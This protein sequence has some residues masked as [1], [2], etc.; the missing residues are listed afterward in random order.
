MEDILMTSEGVPPSHWTYEQ[1]LDD[2]ADLKQGDIL[3]PTPDLNQ[4]LRKHGPLNDNRFLAYVVTTQDCDLV[5][6]DGR[7]DADFVSLAGVISLSAALPDLLEK[8]CQRL[9]LHTEPRIF[10]KKHRQDVESFLRKLFNQNAWKY[11]LFYLHP[12]DAIKIGDPAVAILRLSSSLE[13]TESTYLVLKESRT[14]R[15]SGLFRAKFGWTVGNLFS[16]VG[17]PDWGDKSKGDIDILRKIVEDHLDPPFCL[18][19]P[20][21]WMKSALAA[22]AKLDGLTC[23][24]AKAILEKNKPKPHYCSV[25]ERIIKLAKASLPS[26][27]PSAMDD[28]KKLMLEDGVIKNIKSRAEIKGE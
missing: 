5:L 15:L 3:Q 14:G 28:F 13:L 22:D 16:R 27:T 8:V 1:I 25:V 24:E 21:S 9:P 26:A 6:R 19:M 2:E 20:Q 10:P 18:W 11:G 12:D 7:F 4:L 23:D 17:T